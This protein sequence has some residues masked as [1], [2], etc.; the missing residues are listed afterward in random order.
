[1]CLTLLTTL[2]VGLLCTP[3]P[4][5]RLGQ[6][7]PL[8]KSG[9]GPA[10]HATVAMNSYGDLCVAF[11]TKI[12]AGQQRLVEAQ[13]LRHNGN[14]VWTYHNSDRLILGD[15]N[16]SFYGS[17]RDHCTK[18]DVIVL[19][20]GTFV[21][22]WPRT[23]LMDKQ[24]GRMETARIGIRSPAGQL[25]ANPLLDS[26]GP[27]IGYPLDP[28]VVSGDAG[29][30][31]DL[32]ALPGLG[33][34][35]VYATEDSR[36]VA[37]NSDV[38]RDFTLRVVSMDWAAGPADPNFLSGPYDLVVGLPMD[39]D[40]ASNFAGGLVLPDIVTD[41]SGNLVVA[42]EQ[43]LKEGR[44]G[45]PGTDLGEV[46]IRRFEGFNS[47]APLALMDE[48]VFSAAQP[49]LQQRRPC[50]SSSPDD[51][52]DAVLLSWVSIDN[53]PSASVDVVF[54]EILYGPPGQAQSGDRHWINFPGL[55]EAHPVPVQTSGYQRCFA[56]REYG[57]QRVI[58]TSNATAH[59]MAQVP[60][61]VKFPERVAAEVLET[62]LPGGTPI[63]V[64]MMTYEGANQN[65]ADRYRVYVTAQKL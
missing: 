56:T 35:A 7:V 58:L 20:D 12:G 50:L 31:P 27:G 15:P 62:A 51:A 54:K 26:A 13:I 65:D 17:L 30:M 1:M 42:W 6:T 47:L 46:V 33:A 36:T 10:D 48:N 3:A 2:T 49:D 25:L 45:Y 38:W 40:A 37:W 21:V 8:G 16:V 14:G 52:S 43:Y 41:D 59:T 64:L 22:G 11:Q 28:L 34:V 61:P 57:H 53:S 32:Q 24:V 18:P 4:Q 19:D 44:L 60:S 63:S 9:A 23:D 5:L 55:D 39:S 29:I